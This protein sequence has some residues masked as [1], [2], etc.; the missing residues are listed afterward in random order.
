MKLALQTVICCCVLTTV[1]PLVKGATEELNTSL[2]RRLRVWLQ[3]RMKRDLPDG[4]VT[5]DELCAE[6]LKGQQQDA[7]ENNVSPPPSS[8][9]DNR[10]RRSTK[11]SGCYLVTCSYHDL[12]YK[13]HQLNNVHKDPTA[14]TRQISSTGYGRRRRSL[15]DL[16]QVAPQTGRQRRGYKA[17]HRVRRLESKRTVA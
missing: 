4:F 14:P 17:G 10:P 12:I 13:I 9:L 2:K 1:L 15:L 7:T 16:T 3:N 6:I 5:A 8:G 11:S